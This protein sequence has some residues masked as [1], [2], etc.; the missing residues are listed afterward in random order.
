[1][2]LLCC[3]IFIFSSFWE[4]FFNEKGSDL[5]DRLSKKKKEDE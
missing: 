2:I 1:M 3:I 5:A 4:G